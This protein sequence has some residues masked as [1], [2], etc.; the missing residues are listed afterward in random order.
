MAAAPP[1]EA[2]KDLL[3]P[4][5]IHYPPVIVAAPNLAVYDDL[6]IGRL[7]A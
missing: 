1:M 6:L 7:T 4:P 5:V 3:L 2:V